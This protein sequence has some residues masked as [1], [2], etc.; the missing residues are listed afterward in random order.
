M[1][2]IGK[3]GYVGASLM[4]CVETGKRWRTTG[5]K[6]R[7]D[8]ISAL[9][10]S[11]ARSRG[12]VATENANYIHSFVDPNDFK[13]VSAIN[14]VSLCSVSKMRPSKYEKKPWGTCPTGWQ[15]AYQEWV[16]IDIDDIHGL[17][18]IEHFLKTIVRRVALSDDEFSG[19]YAIV[20]TGPVGVQIWF[21]LA[22]VRY[23]PSKWFKDTSVRNWYKSAGSTILDSLRYMG[24]EGGHVDMSS[25]AAG[26]YGRRPGWRVMPDGSVYRS[27]LIDH[28]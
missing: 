8:P 27:K 23:N 7:S 14:S 1:G 21:Q 24:A 13:D 11:D 22:H 15:A 12:S 20:R 17:D 2:A 16:L 25:C 3:G 28:T 5:Q 6:L 9:L 10:W 4:G 26:R 19:E 18:N